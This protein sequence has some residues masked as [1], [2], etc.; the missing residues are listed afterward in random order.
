VSYGGRV[1]RVP[2]GLRR[3]RSKGGIWGGAE[4][5]AGCGLDLIVSYWGRRFRIVRFGGRFRIVR[6][7]GRPSRL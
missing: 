2:A 6:D 7:W 5:S 1:F 4:A 3:V